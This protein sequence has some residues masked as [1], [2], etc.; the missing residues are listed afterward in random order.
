MD[1]T[2][3][4]RDGRLIRDSYLLK[5]DGSVV[6]KR[7]L[8]VYLPK[9]FLDNGLASIGDKVKTAA[10]LGVVIP[11]VAYAPLISLMSITLCPISSREETVDNVKYVV[12]EFVKDD[13]LVENISV[14]QDPGM[15]YK[16]HMEF[17]NFARKPWY[18]N[19]DDL[20]S[21][22]D[23]SKNE[24]DMQVGTSPQVVR[25]FH[26]LMFRDPDNINNPYRN[27]QAMLEGREPIIMGLNNSPLLADG[28]FPKQMG[29]YLRDNTVAAIV[30]QDT[31]VTDLEKTMKGVPI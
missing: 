3:L 22:Y 15:A 30:N 29:G 8:E 10:V 6:A 5:K 28:T 17:E 26:S 9:K 18:L 14:L 19:K 27:S 7:D 12:L 25:V 21:L 16:Y 2:E 23:N 1:V 20:T 11:G 4:K 13:L 24:C 31:K